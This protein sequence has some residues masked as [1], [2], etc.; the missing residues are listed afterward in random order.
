MVYFGSAAVMVWQ[1]T[2]NPPT[3]VTVGSIPT[4][5]TRTFCFV[6]RYY[7]PQDEKWGDSQGWYYSYRSSVSNTKVLSG[8]EAGGR[9]KCYNYRRREKAFNLGL[10]LFVQRLLLWIVYPFT[11]VRFSHRPPSIL[12]RLVKWYHSWFGTKERKF[13]SCIGDQILYYKQ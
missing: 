6:R 3:L 5:S 7:D 8:R 13:D 11:R 9:Q 2:V 12:L 1:G 4:T 10:G